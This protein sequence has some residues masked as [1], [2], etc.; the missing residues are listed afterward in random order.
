MK[1]PK[2]EEHIH[3]LIKNHKG[4]SGRKH[5]LETKEI[6]RQTALNMTAETKKK[7]SNSSKGKPKSEEHNIKNSEAKKGKKHPGAK[8]IGIFDSNGNKMFSSH[9]DFE[10]VCKENNL[11]FGVLSNS[12]KNDGSGIYLIKSPRN[13]E[14]LK[15]KGWYAKVI[16]S[17]VLNKQKR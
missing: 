13:P 6:M 14:N 7:I 4:M 12:Y 3:N 1:K 2:S 15:F 11:P 9:G 5:T 17:D 10:K 16:T 8:I